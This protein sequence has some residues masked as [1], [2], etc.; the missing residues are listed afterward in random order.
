MK[1]DLARE[2]MLLAMLPLKMWIEADDARALIHL[3]REGK[4][5]KVRLNKLLTLFEPVSC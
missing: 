2:A 5:R 1:R 4:C 3:A